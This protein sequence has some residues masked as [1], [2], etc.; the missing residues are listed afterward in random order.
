MKYNIKNTKLKLVTLLLASSFGVLQSCDDLVNESPISARFTN[1]FF[2]DNQQLRSGLVAAYDAMQESYATHYLRWGEFRSDNLSPAPSARSV[3]ITS[4][5]NSSMDPGAASILR[6][7][8]LYQCIDR[9]N[10]IINSA[11]NIVNLDDDILAQAL[12]I[13]AKV[14][15]DMTRVWGD[16]PVFT[17]AITTPEDAFV[18]VTSSEMIMNDI[19]IPDMLR[20]NE[21]IANNSSEFQFSKVSVLALMAEVYMSFN[22]PS[23]TQLAKEAMSELI[24]LGEH[25]LVT[26]PKDW[27]NLFINQPATDAFPEGPGKVQRGLELMF[28]LKY[29]PPIDFTPSTIFPRYA[30]GGKNTVIEESLEELWTERF[31]LDS[32]WNDL[33]PDTPPVF[34]REVLDDDGVMTEEPIFGDWR[35][36][37]SREGGDFETGVGSV[38]VGEARIH[39]WQKNRAG[40]TNNL[41]ATDLVIYRYADIILLLAEAELKLGNTGPALDLVNEIRTA[42]Q[43]PLVT[44]ADFG[45][46]TDDQ[47]EYILT[48]R[49]FELLG[50]GKRWWDLVRNGLVEETMNPILTDRLGDNAPLITADRIFWPILSEHLIDNP[51]LSQNQGW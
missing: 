33:Y 16:I 32:L 17:E 12:A 36:F 4:I 7:N 25:S 47:L 51:N 39:K 18:N 8:E 14:Y 6:W 35:Y 49:R 48:E 10:R 29:N 34:T 38:D 20:A 27:Q 41:D 45:A 44:M 3:L 37:A 42:R 23:N 1:S 9:T 28:S 11:E 31:P 21:L 22:T 30:G 46:S 43:L 19:V 40:L 50:E 24:A 5:H 13:R 15:F 2:Q 26:S